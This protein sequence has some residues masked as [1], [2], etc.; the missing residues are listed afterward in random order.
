MNPAGTLTYAIRVDEH[1]DDHWCAW[2]GGRTLTRNGDGTSTLTAAVA[3]QAQLHGILTRLR[4]IG[5]TLLDLRATE[6]AH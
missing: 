4:D 3:D 6:P 2:L 1:L 5:A